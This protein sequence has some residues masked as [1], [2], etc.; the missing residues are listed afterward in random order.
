[1]QS[2]MMLS[3]ATWGIVG[4]C[5]GSFVHVVATRLPLRILD[6]KDAQV[7]TSNPR[8]QCAHCQCNL[9]WWALVPVL[10]W[11]LLKGRSACCNKPIG[12]GYPLVELATSVWFVWCC[13]LYAGAD[14]SWLTIALW[15]VW[16]ALLL[17][18]LLIDYNYFL[19][20]DSLTLGLLALGI[21]GSAAS[22]TGLPVLQSLLG[23]AC[24]GSALWLVA[25]GYKK[26]TGR[27]GMG[28]GDIKLFAALGAW[29][30][31]AALPWV[32]LG[33]SLA[34]LLWGL[35]LGWVQRYAHTSPRAHPPAPM[36]A[37]GLDPAA[38]AFGPYLVISAVACQVL[39]VSAA[40]V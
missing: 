26:A 31:L 14:H 7:L 29:L 4:L 6:I 32:L 11:L 2:S 35:G 17:C 33:A 16:G 22:L 5:V 40:F 36:A 20:P 8:S 18:C 23:T 27:D 1:M 30:G 13:Y 15:S 28:L 25:W 3:L 21:A 38:I 39:G 34:G 37:L 12:I 10:S 19:L 24:G 9:P